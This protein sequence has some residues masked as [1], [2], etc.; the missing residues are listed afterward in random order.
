MYKRIL[1]VLG[2]DPASAQ[3]SSTGIEMAKAHHADI[4]FFYVMPRYEVL[5]AGEDRMA[6]A[7]ASES[8]F[9]QQA[10]QFAKQKLACAAELAERE[11]IFSLGATGQDADA[12]MCVALAAQNRH[13]QLIVVATERKNA[14][15]RMI[16]GSIVPRLL[17]VATVPVLVCSTVCD[18]SGRHG[19]ETGTRKRSTPRLHF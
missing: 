9:Q 2:D 4:L 7:S 14:V 12:A 11:G 3:A 6:L 5:L 1:V 19:T 16:S 15:M 8:D 18:K 17:T 10:T 13:C